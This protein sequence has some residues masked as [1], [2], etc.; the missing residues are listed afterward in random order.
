MNKYQKYQYRQLTKDCEIRILKLQPS[1]QFNSPLV[2]SVHHCDLAK[3]IN[4]VAHEATEETEDWTDYFRHLE[5]ESSHFNSY[6]AISYA[7]GDGKPTASLQ[8]QDAGIMATLAM[9]PNVDNLLRHLRYVHQERSLWIDSLCI[10]QDDAKEKE[11]QV[12]FMSRIYSEAS[13]VLVWLGASTDGLDD[14]GYL[15]E[16]L[17]TPQAASKDTDIYQLLEALLKRPWF[18]RRWIVQEVLLAKRAT[19]LC[20]LHAIDLTSF[21]TCLWR[22]TQQGGMISS[23]ADIVHK[24]CAIHRFRDSFL[25]K[26]RSWILGMLVVFHEAECSDDRDRIYALDG[27]TSWKVLVS[28]T[29]TVEET[30]V[31]YATKHIEFENVALLN[32]SGAF[33]S[34]SQILPSWV[35]DWRASPQFTPVTTGF[36]LNRNTEVFKGCVRASGSRAILTVFGTVM[37][38][39]RQVGATAPYPV[40]QGDLL[41]LLMDWHDLSERFTKDFRRIFSRSIRVRFI[42][43]ITLGAI[44]PTETTHSTSGNSILDHLTAAADKELGSQAPVPEKFRG[45]DSI[46]HGLTFSKSVWSNFDLTL[47]ATIFGDLA[48]REASTICS[49]AVFED[50]P[51]D[52]VRVLQYTTGGRKCF[53]TNDGSFGFGPSAMQPGDIIVE[54][55]PGHTPYVL[56]PVSWQWPNYNIGMAAKKLLKHPY[57]TIVGDCYIQSFTS[58]THAARDQKYRSFDIT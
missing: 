12:Q 52:F 13:S 32:C 46:L 8:V 1:Q 22:F 35:P 20:G 29:E 24:L 36:S 21:T 5:M 47:Y 56:R 51:Q 3:E 7:W 40:K 2:A 34:D 16:Q 39:V 27:I 38:T 44:E 41:S 42:E 26:G 43:I 9:R 11:K 55:P 53:I 57:Y 14:V 45:L 15:F 30:Y 58:K 10:N 54:I 19:L 6:E 4:H 37:S 28:Y 23:V 18:R 48:R 33:R 50:S 49:T 31:R 17:S 25:Y